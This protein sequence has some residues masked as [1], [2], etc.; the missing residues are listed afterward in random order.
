MRHGQTDWNITWKLQGR[1][2][3]PLN[4]NGREQAAALRARLAGVRLD[5]A[6]LSQLCRA[7]P[8]AHIQLRGTNDT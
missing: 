7:Q 8:T 1:A 4:A 3:I 6:Y 5:A 2:D